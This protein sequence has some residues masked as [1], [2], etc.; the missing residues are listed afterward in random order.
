MKKRPQ[1]QN[2]FSELR[3]TAIEIRR[4]KFPLVNVQTKEGDWVEAQKIHEEGD[5][6]T[7]RWTDVRAERGHVVRTV[8][9]KTFD[10]WQKTRSEETHD[11]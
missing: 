4:N 8:F 9:R 11:K 5:R 7:V 6:I 1:S 2:D 3:E 10:R